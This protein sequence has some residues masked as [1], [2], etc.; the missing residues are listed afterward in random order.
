LYQDE[1][2]KVIASMKSYGCKRGDF[3]LA[4]VNT[5]TPGTMEREHKKIVRTHDEIR[6]EQKSMK[7]KQKQA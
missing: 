7:E 3:V 1:Y 2:D 6:K 5:A 4:C